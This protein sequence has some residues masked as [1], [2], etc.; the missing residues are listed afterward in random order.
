MWVPPE[1]HEWPIS[2]TEAKRSYPVEYA[3]F[4]RSEQNLLKRKRVEAIRQEL[5]TLDQQRQALIDELSTLT[6]NIT[7]PGA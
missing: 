4:I 5:Q 1:P 7:L 2:E 3:E 6:P